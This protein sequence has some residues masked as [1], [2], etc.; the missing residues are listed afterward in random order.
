MPKTKF[1]AYVEHRLR[2]FFAMR[3]HDGPYRFLIRR[4][5]RISDIELASGVLGTEFFRRQLVPVPLP[6]TKVR[7]ILVIA[8]HQD[9]EVIGAGGALLLAAR[10]GVRID[11]L[12]L[13]DGAQRKP[14]AAADRMALMRAEEARR[15]CERLGATA[16]S[17]NISNLSPAPTMAH[18][19]LLA[20][21][22]QELKP[23]VIMLPWLLDSPPKHRITNHLLWLA[24]QRVG[25]PN[26]EVW[27]YQI[28][29]SL[30]PNGYVDI[31]EVA[32]A[33]RELIDYYQSQSRFRCYAHIA[34]GLA[35]WNT[36]FLTSCPTPKYIEVFFTLPLLE[37]LRLVETFYFVDFKATYMRD[38]SV[39]PGMLDLHHTVTRNGNGGRR[40]KPLLVH[41]ST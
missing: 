4:W 29:N 16:Q 30:M 8:P 27:G 15:V 38:D 13:T 1:T 3:A 10:A 18:L 36:H 32:D 20:R 41:E 37:L 22:I 2:E 34:M 6:I 17:L 5:N 28:H 7:S 25:L 35:A 26:S 33:K 9:D 19:D 14:G 23:E 24:H 21:K 11:V 12:Y 40:E 39:I 31:T